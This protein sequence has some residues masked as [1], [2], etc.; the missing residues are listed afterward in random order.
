M[1]TAVAEAAQDQLRLWYPQFAPAVPPLGSAAVRAW[2]GRIQ[3][4]PDGKEFAG[5]MHHFQTQQTVDVKKRGR[6][7]HP[8]SCKASHHFSHNFSQLIGSTFEIV[9]L[10]FAGTRHPRV[11]AVTPEISRRRYP[12][13]PHLR[14]DQQVII[15][16]KPLQ[17]LCTYL[18]SDGVRPRG[19]MELVHALDYTSMFLAKHLLWV[20]TNFVNYYSVDDIHVRRTANVAALMSGDDIFVFDGTA[21]PFAAFYKVGAAMEHPLQQLERWIARKAWKL[22]GGVWIGGGAPHQIAE[23]YREIKPWQECHCGSGLPYGTCHRN[24]DARALGLIR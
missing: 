5:V 17:A 3:P 15:S 2:T 20:A 19:E 8:A 13:H 16:G 10:E 9:A 1:S 24:A 12:N 14:D 23:M 11:Y 18:A 6:L 7:C 21:G 4:F 22:S